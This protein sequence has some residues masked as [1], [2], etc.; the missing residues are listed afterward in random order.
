MSAAPDARL[1][2]AAWLSA[3]AAGTS[4]PSVV[5]ERS[6][7]IADIY[8]VR[9]RD[10]AE[11]ERSL[12]EKFHPQRVDWKALDA[13][14]W[15]VSVYFPA[16]RVRQNIAQRLAGGLAPPAP[17]SSW[18]AAASPFFFLSVLTFPL[19]VI[20]AWVCSLLRLVDN[21]LTGGRCAAPVAGAWEACTGLA[22]LAAQSALSLCVFLAMGY[23]A[24]RMWPALLRLP[25]YLDLNV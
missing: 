1:A 3:V 16:D 6:T 4:R 23:A 14:E 24:V 18:L 7:E 10:P 20:F 21:T 15:R 8:V 19:R 17:A 25:A 5:Y 2:A 12:R 13:G 9:G 11:F 22:V